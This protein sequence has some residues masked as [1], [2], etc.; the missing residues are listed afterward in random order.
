V[1]RGNDHIEPAEEALPHD[2]AAAASSL[3]Y[4]RGPLRFS[5]YSR[6]MMLIGASLALI[7]F[8]VT[9]LSIQ[10][11]QMHRTGDLRQ[12][13]AAQ[14]EQQALSVSKALWDLNR[15]GM[16]TILKG[17]A[18]DPDFVFATV[19]DENGRAF[20]HI[21]ADNLGSRAI[22]RAEASII[23]DDNGRRRS[24]GTLILAFSLDGLKEEQRAETRKALILGLAQLA[25][26]LLATAL[27]LYLVMRPLKEIT[28]RM[29]GVADGALD[30]GV[31]HRERVDQIGDIARAV[32]VF[33]REA[34]ER[35]K[36]EQALRLAHDDLERRVQERT[37]ELSVSEERLR[38]VM[39]NV[40]DAIITI[41]RRGHI[42]SANLAAQSIFGYA[43]DELIGVN[44]KMLMLSAD[45]ARHDEHIAKYLATGQAAFLGKG[46]R[47][48][49]GRHKNGSP[50]ALE[51]AIDEMHLSGTRH[52]VG[53]ARNIAERKE[54]EHRLQQAQ[55]MEAV[56]Q[57]TGGV[58]HDFNNLLTVILGNSELLTK[59]L[60]SDPKLHRLAAMSAK[61]AQRGADLTR[62]LLAF[63]RKQLLEPKLT[64]VNRLI[65]RMDGLLRRSLGED[66]EIATVT[67]N[68][69][70]ETT[71]DPAK[72]EAAL[73][74]LALNARDAMPEGGKLTIET[75]NVALDQAYA[76]ENE[77]V[78]PGDYVMIA[79]TDTG[80]GM[81]ADVLARAFD[82]FFTTKEVGK[83]TGL[84]LS[85]VYGF[86]K[87][88]NGH[89]RLYSEVGLGTSVR[90]YLPRSG[91]TGAQSDARAPLTELRGG[92]ETI[93]MVED[94]DMVRASVERQ[95]GELGYRVLTARNA[96]EALELM[97]SSQAIDL[98]FTDIVMPGGMNG[99]QLAI[100][101]QHLRPGLK[102]L[103]T[104]GYTE[105]AA[106][107]A[108]MIDA[109]EL[110]AKP[111]RRHDLAAKLRAAF[112]G[113][114]PA[115]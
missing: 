80:C 104:S 106:M 114:A 45:G 107:H 2:K 36:A 28:T 100:E 57:L 9:F 78:G 98:L 113:Q 48:V 42:E 17:V 44:I 85:M 60:S 99:A 86:A 1:P 51:L 77:G 82:P 34:A 59:A 32:E 73:L 110:L 20:L 26:V 33:R 13:L 37:R 67:A 15:E 31:P 52:F 90:V 25:A 3:G 112:E 29:L 72:L 101:A 75:G 103:Y 58:A 109:G 7:T 70:W 105:K 88:S 22:E 74:N 81:S 5:I 19:L 111:Y 102:V 27:A 16:A 21:G 6:A 43:A 8:F 40:T 50:I 87:Q 55:K 94:D 95:L 41:D 93:L 30:K 79:V 97:R 84:G 49:T 14:T 46:P 65:M 56:G 91:E 115:A 108:G 68:G 71:V 38:G 23:L 54:A 64:D 92:S 61:A 89:V 83:G 69:L 24:I 76:K 4:L 53:V 66:I 39:D 35:R 18:I 11:D 12:R 47:E 10:N 62:S 96:K 63:S